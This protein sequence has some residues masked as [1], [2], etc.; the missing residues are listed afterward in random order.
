ML[1]QALPIAKEM[2]LER[3]LITC[4]EDNIASARVMEKNGC[5]YEDTVDCS[6]GSRTKR[7]WKSL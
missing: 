2:G 1:K 3:V 5:Q 7:Y 6:D 4:N